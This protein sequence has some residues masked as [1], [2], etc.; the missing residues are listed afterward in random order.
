MAERRRIYN[1]MAER[2][3]DNTMAERRTDNAMA[4]RRRIDNTMTERRTDNT[5][6]ER[7]RKDNTMA[8]RR[9]D[10]TMTE[11]RS[12]YNTMSER[13]GTEGQITIY[14]TF[15]QEM[16]DRAT[17]TLLKTKCDIM[18]SGGVSISSFTS[19]T[20]RISLVTNPVLV[21]KALRTMAWVRKK[22]G[23]RTSIDKQPR[24]S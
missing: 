7:R 11:T 15:K 2:R 20:R 12:T 22:Y 13:K 10:N 5:M 21:L 24:T 19:E 3:T 14:K 16:K 17:R 18:C 23:S 8:E 4:E 9:T 1:T 6:T